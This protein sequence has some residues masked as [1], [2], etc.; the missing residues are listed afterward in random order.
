MCVCRL[1]DVPV[2][3]QV[4]A[5]LDTKDKIPYVSE[6]GGMFYN[7]WKDEKNKVT[8]HT[9][10]HRPTGFLTLP[11]CLAASLCSTAR[12]LSHFCAFLTSH[13]WTCL[14]RSVGC[15]GGRR[16]SP[17]AQRRPSGR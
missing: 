4:L 13:T 17:T 2:M 6:V 11:C 1:T 16:S 10:V 15:G 9:F 8:L 7:L 3:L 5:A 14:F 12:P